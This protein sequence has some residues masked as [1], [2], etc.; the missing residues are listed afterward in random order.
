[1]SFRRNPF[2]GII[3][4]NGKRF[5]AR[6]IIDTL[7]QLGVVVDIDDTG[8]F[9]GYKHVPPVT[10][11]MLQQ[12][13]ERGELNPTELVPITCGCNCQ[14]KIDNLQQLLQ[15]LLSM[16]TQLL[17]SLSDSRGSLPSS[18]EP[19]PS[20]V[21]PGS[22]A[23]FKDQLSHVMPRSAGSSPRRYPQLNDQSLSGALRPS[24]SPS[25]SQ[26]TSAAEV[27]P[28]GQP[29]KMDAATSTNPWN[30]MDQLLPNSSRFA[31]HAK[32][33]EPLYPSRHSRGGQTI[34]A[35][36][37]FQSIRC[38]SCKSPLPSGSLFCSKCG[39]KVRT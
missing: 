19:P 29:I 10:D 13:I 21:P 8:L 4:V 38:H 34:P 20:T 26:S 15:Q 12:L 2:Q 30:L 37:S 16:M 23:S 35:V 22:S 18:R 39:A 7:V 36:S 14:K 32:D 28:S 6:D 5:L 31:Q 33:P 25:L 3:T 1:M 17:A 9:I 11:D 24:S 27:R